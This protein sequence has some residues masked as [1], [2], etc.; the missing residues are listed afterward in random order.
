QPRRPVADATADLARARGERLVAAAGLARP[1]AAGAH[2]FSAG[3]G[4]VNRGPRYDRA[5]ASY[6]GG[7]RRQ[8]VCAL[9]V[10]VAVGGAERTLAVYNA[11]RS[12]LPLLAAL[13]ANAPLYGGADTGLASVRPAICGM[14]PRQGIPPA[15]ESWDGFAE[16]LRWG[17]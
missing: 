17:V 8:L 7:A 1:A 2:P 16:A 14:L 10:H 5:T 13:A 9:Q 6:R 15:L 3:Q 4:Q 12:E 11:L